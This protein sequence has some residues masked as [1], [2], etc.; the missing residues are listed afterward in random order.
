[1]IEKRLTRLLTPEK[2]TNARKHQRLTNSSDCKV[3]IWAGGDR[4]NRPIHG[5][6]NDQMNN[7]INDPMNF[8]KGDPIGD[9]LNGPINDQMAQ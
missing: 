9:L 8:S 7:P 2:G 3:K 4:M 1:M 6:M 5:L